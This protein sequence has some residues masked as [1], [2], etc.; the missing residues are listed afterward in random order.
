MVYLQLIYEFIK[1]GLFSI[2][3]GLATLPFVFQMAEKY[4]WF[5]V[6]ELANMIAVSTSTPG[7][8]GVNITTYAGL[9][10]GGVLGGVLASLALSL[11]SVVI[12]TFLAKSFEKYKDSK[13]IRSAFYG[14][15]PAV[16]ALIAY[17]G[18]GIMKTAL[19]N[20]EL[21]QSTLNIIDLFK[22]IPIII[23]ILLL[24]FTNRFKKHPIFYI[25][26]A[27]FLGVI[28]KL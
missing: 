13:L 11:P 21:Y 26:I 24:F 1:A 10:A 8:I 15:R 18:I 20:L 14:I 27:G 2:G 25:A 4:P 17:A 16:T 19:L 5:T 6:S 3:G 7:P 9:M 23:F 28:L 22:V 12:S